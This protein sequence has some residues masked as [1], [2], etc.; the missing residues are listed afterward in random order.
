MSKGQKTEPRKEAP[1]VPKESYSK[2]LESTTK[3]QEQY[4]ENLKKATD[5]L[6]S[7][8]KTWMEATS[9]M[10]TVTPDIMKS[11]VTSEAY[12]SVYD[13]WIKQ[14]ETLNRLMGIP[15]ATPIRESIESARDVTESYLRGFDIYTKSY[16]LWIDLAKKNMEILSQ[17]MAEIQ[18]MML[19]TYKTLTP[20]FS[21][22]EEERT[23]IYDWISESIKKSIE[24]TTAVIRKQL[25]TLTKVVEELSLSVKKL[26][27][28]V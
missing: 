20:L 3:L 10:T 16:A 7:L 2:A 27:K 11:G 13:F 12:R 18:K 17:N 6:I 8:Q 15:T 21:V 24:T 1:N 19:E 22:P 25:E 26:A 4:F 14:F 9:K 28:A 5:Y 23:K